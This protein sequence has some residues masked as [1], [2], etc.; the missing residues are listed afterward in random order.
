M[1]LYA[2]YSEELQN[3]QEKQRKSQMRTIVILISEH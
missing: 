1:S 2:V 3:T